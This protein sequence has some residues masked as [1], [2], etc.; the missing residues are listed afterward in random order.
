MA[1]I[2]DMKDGISTLLTAV[3]GIGK[4]YKMHK[5]IKKPKDFAGTFTVGNPAI[6]NTWEITNRSIPESPAGIGSGANIRERTWDW[7]IE[8]WYEVN[9]SDSEVTFDNLVEAICTKFRSQNN[10]GGALCQSDTMQVEIKDIDG[11]N[12]GNADQEG[13]LCH[14]AVLSL[15]ISQRI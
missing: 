10:I 6:L 14:H 2:Q 4:V 3:S 11:F 5:I 7:Q 12:G 13:I 9:Y 15:P 1:S 8:G